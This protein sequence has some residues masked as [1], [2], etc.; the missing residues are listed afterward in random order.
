MVVMPIGENSRLMSR[1][2]VEK[3]SRWILWTVYPFKICDA[4]VLATVNVQ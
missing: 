4:F 3:P 1:D 2:A